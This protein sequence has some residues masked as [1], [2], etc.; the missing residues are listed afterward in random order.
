MKNVRKILILI[1]CAV[2]LVCATVIGTFAYLQAM[3]PVVKN[4]FVAGQI[5]LDL[6]EYEINPLTGKMPEGAVKCKGVSDIKMIPGRF[7]EK[8]PTVTVEANSEACYLRTFVI[9]RWLPHADPVFEQTSYAGWIKFTSDWDARLVFDGSFAI[10]Q[11]HVGYAVFELKYKHL[12][13]ASNQP[14]D[15]LVFSGIQVPGDLSNRQVAALDGVHVEVIAQAVQA[16]GFTA[17]NIGGVETS[18]RDNAFAAVSN[19]QLIQ[20]LLNWQPSNTDDENVVEP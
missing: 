12:V 11:E 1:M 19:P 14:Q 16:E 4:T 17:T 18:A 20:D 2:L 6:W 3:T 10:R 5:G 9:I 8:K 15:I 7:I 13:P